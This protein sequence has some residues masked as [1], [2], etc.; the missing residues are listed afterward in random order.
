MEER[1]TSSQILPENWN[2]ETVPL[3]VTDSDLAAKSISVYAFV[4]YVTLD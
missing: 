4:Y 2:F 3:F 1:D